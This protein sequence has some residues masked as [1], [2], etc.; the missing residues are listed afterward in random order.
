MIRGTH[1]QAKRSSQEEAAERGDIGF[2]GLLIPGPQKF[3][4]GHGAREAQQGRNQMRIDV[5]SLIV[6]VTE[7]TEGPEIRT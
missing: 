1:T 2:R 6:P 5:D 7:A 4:R 3:I